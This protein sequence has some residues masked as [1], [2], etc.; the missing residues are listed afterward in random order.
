MSMRRPHSA[1]V[2]DDAP[3]DVPRKD[4]RRSALPPSLAPRGLSRLQ[5]A[6]YIG[7]SPS[8][9][10]KLIRDHV[11]PPQKRLGGRVVWDRKQLDEALDALDAESAWSDDTAADANSWDQSFRHA[12][13]TQIHKR[14]RRSAW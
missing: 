6:E 13:E 1:V 12:G 8:H 3:R 11:M 2:N 7:V 5:A 4:D 14:R 10:D 9:F